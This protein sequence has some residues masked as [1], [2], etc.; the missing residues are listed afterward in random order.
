MPST[1]PRRTSK[2]T[3]ST[4]RTQPCSSLKSTV[5][6]RAARIGAMAWRAATSALVRIEGI[7]Q[8]VGYEVK[9]EQGDH[10][11]PAWQQQQS[12]VGAEAAC[13]IF[14]ERS[15]GAGRRLDAEA[16]K[17]QS[18]LGDDDFEDQQAGI[19]DHHIQRI[20]HDMLPD[21]LPFGHSARARR[22][23]ELPV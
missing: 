2:L 6:S 7:A 3:P 8:P 15:P 14:D 23:H 10:E 4:A 18:G 20:G 17:A 1:S 5:R 11:Q 12:Q 19:H 13:A 16:K 9:A 22:V 21:D